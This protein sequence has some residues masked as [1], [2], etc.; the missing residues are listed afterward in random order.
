[1]YVSIGL[2][3]VTEIMIFCFEAGRKHPYNLI[4]LGVFTLAQ[5]YLVSFIAAIVADNNGGAVVVMAGIMT[6]GIY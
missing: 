1:M 6:L 2:M 3:L 4:A 5:A